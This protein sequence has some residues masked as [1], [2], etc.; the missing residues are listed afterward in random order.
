M[1][2]LVI[3]IVGFWLGWGSRASEDSLMSFVDILAFLLTASVVGI[4]LFS[5]LR[6]FWS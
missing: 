5:G 3:G 6:Q 4:L 2:F 1:K